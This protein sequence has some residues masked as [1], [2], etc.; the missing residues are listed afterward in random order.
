MRTQNVKRFKC[1]KC[2]KCANVK[3]AKT[4]KM[5]NVQRCANCVK[6]EMCNAN[7]GLPRDQGD[8]DQVGAQL[9]P[10][11]AAEPS[12][13][14]AHMNRLRSAIANT[15]PVENGPPQ[16][17]SCP[18]KR[19]SPGA[20]SREA[21]RS[22]RERASASAR[23][24][25]PCSLLREPAGTPLCGASRARGARRRRWQRAGA[26]SSEAHACAAHI[27]RA[28]AARRLRRRPSS[29]LRWQAAALARDGRRDRTE[30]CGGG[31]RC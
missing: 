6:C 30:R 31:A 29:A 18:Q 21:L 1:V 11:A 16:E 9:V 10:A 19:S 14:R 12:R 23:A 3:F 17:R 25:R 28:C 26:R 7:K 27:A 15:P 20:C 5:S 22:E 8:R 13:A 4:C 2:V 24:R